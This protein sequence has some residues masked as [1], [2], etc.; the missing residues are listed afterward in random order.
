MKEQTYLHSRHLTIINSMRKE[1]RR[2]EEK[3]AE[4]SMAMTSPLPHAT[5]RGCIG[6]NIERV[7][8]GGDRLGGGV[9]VLCQK[10]V[11]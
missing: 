4:W 11:V 5:K 9:L 10:C 3:E 2:I 6:P 7:R 8:Y 1:M